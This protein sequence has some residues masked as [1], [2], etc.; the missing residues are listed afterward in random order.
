MPDPTLLA[1]TPACEVEINSSIVR[2]LLQEQHPDLQALPLREMDAGWDNAMF[3]LGDELAVRLPR[4][5]VA[6]GLIEHEQVWLPRLAPRLTL[7][8]PVPVRTG[9]PSELYPW[10]WSVVPWIEGVS[11]NRVSLG[12]GEVE[13]FVFF[14]RFATPLCACRRANQSI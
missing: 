2:R 8:V 7:P 14:L 5:Q 12:G 1:G 11:A 13:R 10:R 9:M 4:R 6:A 3:R